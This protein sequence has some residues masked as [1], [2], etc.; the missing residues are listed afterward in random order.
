MVSASFTQSSFL[1]GAWSQFAQGKMTDPRYK[2]AL[3]VML[4]ALPTEEGVFIRRPG[5]RFLAHTR[6]GAQGVLR[7]FDFSTVQ[8]Y[9]MEFT[10][11]YLRFYAG[12]A[13]ITTSDS[14]GVFVERVTEDTPAKVIL[15]KMPAG[16]ANNDT[17]IFELSTNPCTAPL[18]CGRQFT[19]HNKSATDLSFTL[20]D[21]LT[22][23]DI[24]GSDIAYD[25]T[26]IT[27]ADEPDAIKKVFELAT[28]YTGTSFT[29]VRAVQD[30]TTVVLLHGSYQ[31]RVITESDPFAIAAQ[32]F[33]DGPFL[34]LNDTATT[35]ALSG[36]SGSVTVTASAALFAA[37]DVGRL[38]RFQGGPAQW[39]IG[40]TY[41]K[42]ATV[43][44]TD[45][46]V[47]TSLIGA[48]LAHNPTTDDGTNWELS[49]QVVT[50]TWLKITAYTSATQ[51]TALISGATLPASGATTAWRLGVFSDTTGWPTCGCYHEG[52]LML[53]GAVGNRV[54][55]SK[56][57]DHF[58]FSPTDTDGTVADDNA[59]AYIFNAK[60]VN[61]I[62]WLLST[63]DGIICGTQAGE[64][65]IK[66]TALDDPLSPSSVQ[67]RRVS[68]YGCANIEPAQPGGQTVFV[69]RQK[70]K[71]MGHQQITAS[72]YKADNIAMLADHLTVGGI[73]EI[74]WQQ[75]PV[76]T[77]WMRRADGELIGC[78][79]KQDADKADDFEAF[80]EHALANGRV[81]ESI[82][83]GPSYDGLSETLYLISNQTDSD[84]PD[85]NV[86]WVEA[87][88]PTFDT[89]SE[90]WE[91]FYVD[92]AAN[93]C[94]AVR[95][96]I[97]NG[98]AID[99]LRIY[100]LWNLNGKTITPFV[101]GLDLGDVE[102]TDG[103]ADIAYGSDPEGAFTLAFLTAASSGDDFGPFAL[104]ASFVVTLTPAVPPI[105]ANTLLGLVGPDTTVKG[106]YNGYG[107]MDPDNNK[108]YE[109]DLNSGTKVAGLRRFECAL[110]AEEQQADEVQIFGNGAGSLGA[111]SSVVAYDLNDVVTGSNGKTYIS[112][113][114]GV[115]TNT[116]HD[117]VTD[118]N[119]HWHIFGA[120][121][122]SGLSYKHP[123]GFI[124]AYCDTANRAVLAKI[125]ASTLAVAATFG[126][127]GSSFAGTDST[128]IQMGFFSMAGPRVRTGANSYQNY[129]SS[130]GI[131][132]AAV[133]NEINVLD[134]DAMTFV[135]AAQIDEP[136]ASITTG[137]INVGRS[138]W[139]AIGHDKYVSAGATD[140]GFYEYSI[141]NSAAVTKRKFKVLTPPGIDATWTNVSAIIGPAFDKS[142][143][144]LLFMAETTDVVA[145]KKY[146]VKI[147]VGTGAILWKYALPTSIS[148]LGAD[149][150]MSTANINGTFA[151]YYNGT[152]TVYEI[153]TTAGT[154]TLVPFNAGMLFAGAFGQ[155]FDYISGSLT[156]FC[157][158]TQTGT[159]VPTYLG[160]YLAAHS[161]QL[162]SQWGRIF[163]GTTYPASTTTTYTIPASVG[164]AFTSRGQL[165]RPDYGVDA[166]AQNGPAFGKKRRIHWYAASFYRT[167]KVS[168]GTDFAKLKPVPFKTGGGTVYAAPSL[169]SGIVSTTLD[170]DYSFE[171]Q[172]AWEITRPYPLNMQALGGYID[173]QDK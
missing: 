92:G 122:L 61:T 37:T 100:G 82:S 119:S 149:Y 68:T 20:K 109:V 7:E 11:A 115:D 58:N 162:S 53:S 14:D 47:Y 152:D 165:L 118:D 147:D 75:E 26:K 154:A 15:N 96:A 148:S 83:A 25:L 44:G 95:L 111:W 169:F 40:T 144:N 52:R 39:A 34:D 102:V 158:Y 142:D 145:T 163:L 6:A 170:S 19:L 133:T 3:N 124:Y 153:N 164:T 90:D 128:H 135:Y 86:R 126:I 10:D 31:P 106:S 81:V 16:W 22:G 72:R 160:A 130:V 24:D 125:T 121:S 76:L 127:V 35:L 105:A 74:Q 60:D 30:D 112:V 18:L 32:D 50:W 21:A 67:A 17:V 173:T 167:R 2:S 104:G 143:G 1:G 136:V 137:L 150:S 56:S 131:R 59:V 161:N 97:S 129:I 45:G 168:I 107:L 57:N 166:G 43:T 70:R 99:G 85:Y 4:N 89:G 77:L 33:E 5:S 171:G 98:D 103:F 23:V 65:R 62:F 66:A 55:G 157:D 88:M 84:E 13:L 28:P 63:D 49:D 110:G 116:N 64:W 101:G 139:Y 51:V 155:Y 69:Q 48:N 79:Y 29:S 138:T 8:P 94:C 132:S 113:V 38:I 141:D 117:P 108:F 42:N 93:P 73:E 80:S 123:N 36:L 156:F 27:A 78:T 146:L 172:I 12:L 134:A 159:P 151:F 54:D 91:A 87:L 9:Q 120:H 114:A 71:I 140:I 41:A 46:N